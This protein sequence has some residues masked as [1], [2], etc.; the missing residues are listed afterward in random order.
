VCQQHRGLKALHRPW[1]SRKESLLA[2]GCVDSLVGRGNDMIGKCDML[3]IASNLVLQ[4]CPAAA[5]ACPIGHSLQSRRC[6]SIAPANFCLSEQHWRTP[7]PIGT[8]L[9]LDPPSLT[10]HPQLR[11]PRSTRHPFATHS[12]ARLH[13]PGSRQRQ[14]ARERLVPQLE[15][16]G[17]RGRARGEYL[18]RMG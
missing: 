14:P 10:H 2:F 11:P 18:R 1:C 7:L 17:A 6:L 8:L 4:G 12:G 3:S 16:D 15:P 9:P 13:L 5:V